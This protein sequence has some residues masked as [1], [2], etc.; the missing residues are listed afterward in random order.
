M[1]D[2]CTSE[3]PFPLFRPACLCFCLSYTSVYTLCNC[4]LSE[5]VCLTAAMN[6]VYVCSQVYLSLRVWSWSVGVLLS[7]IYKCQLWECIYPAEKQTAG[8]AFFTTS[9]QLDAVLKLEAAAHQ[10][11]PVFTQQRWLGR[12]NNNNL[13]S[14]KHIM[15]HVALINI[16]IKISLWWLKQMRSWRRLAASI[17]RQSVVTAN[18]SQ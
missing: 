15:L 12:L 9:W 1:F 8:K 4:L 11:F 16:D 18:V 6:A 2:Q 17:S 10:C 14:I 13:K 7:V 5:S 3:S